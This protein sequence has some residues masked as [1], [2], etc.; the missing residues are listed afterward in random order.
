M[1][2]DPDD[3]PQLVG[4]RPMDES[5]SVRKFPD[6]HTIVTAEQLASVQYRGATA[7]A[8]CHG[9]KPKCQWPLTSFVIH[10][11]QRV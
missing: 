9:N 7:Y 6:M 2:T 5:E 8:L 1:V 3:D 11:A 4:R 10:L